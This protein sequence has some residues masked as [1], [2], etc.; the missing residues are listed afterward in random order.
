MGAYSVQK[1]LNAIYDTT[2]GCLNTGRAA[3]V[4]TPTAQATTDTYADVTGSTLDTLN[5]LCASYT[6]VENNVNAIKWK[7]LASNTSAFTVA[8]EAQAEAVVA[9]AGSSSFST[10]AAVWRYYKVQVKASVGSSQGNVTVV[11]IT[12]A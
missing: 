5:K 9:Q 11:G 8:V 4:V 1:I 6:I 12:K 3:T 2:N 7:V 10:A